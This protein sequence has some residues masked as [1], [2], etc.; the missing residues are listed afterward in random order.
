MN[1]GIDAKLMDA[2][3]YMLHGGQYSLI[4]CHPQGF[5]MHP[6]HAITDLPLMLDAG[7]LCVA[8][9]DW[10]FANAILTALLRSS[11]SND[12]I[13]EFPMATLVA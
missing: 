2:D 10:H 9:A 11:C 7:G 8:T 4:P 13:V 12:V 1:S 5:T 3:N 6:T